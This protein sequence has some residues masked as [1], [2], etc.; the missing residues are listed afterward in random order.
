MEIDFSEVFIGFVEK[1]DLSDLKTAETDNEKSGP[2]GRIV[3]Q[4]LESKAKKSF[5]FEP[6]GVIENV[7]R[8]LKESGIPVAV[9]VQG[10][11]NKLIFLRVGFQRIQWHTD[12][13]TSI[14]VVASGVEYFISKANPYFDKVETIKMLDDSVENRLPYW[15]VYLDTDTRPSGAPV[16]IVQMLFPRVELDCPFSAFKYEFVEAQT[17]PISVH[18]AEQIFK[19]LKQ[20]SVEPGCY[21]SSGIPFR[22]VSE[23]CEQ[24]A[25][26]MARLI[27]EKKVEPLKIWGFHRDPKQKIEFKTDNHPNCKVGWNFHVAPTVLTT[28]G[29]YVID[30]STMP[31]AVPVAHWHKAMGGKNVTLYSTS[32][33]IYSMERGQCWFNADPTFKEAQFRLKIYRLALYQMWYRFKNPP[34]KCKP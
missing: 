10:G 20:L 16:E 17:K 30:P 11:T 7:V 29:L 18:D 1:F 27:L 34:Y 31:D 28:S 5:E 3:V 8:E 12:L 19:E 25:H 9:F 14:K 4:A 2:L 15:F 23:G 6:D 21:V 32:H 33:S 26:E 22:F 13:G 24:R